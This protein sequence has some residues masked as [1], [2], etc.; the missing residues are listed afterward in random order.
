MSQLGRH[1]VLGRSHLAAL[2]FPRLEAAPVQ[3]GPTDL[4]P[5]VESLQRISER[6]PLRRRASLNFKLVVH[7]AAPHRI[8]AYRTSPACA[9]A[10]DRAA[11]SGC[12]QSAAQDCFAGFRSED[13]L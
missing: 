7:L 1:A 13:W 4:R 5:R 6:L 10:V 3:N 8:A 12:W 9:V 11:R 2:E